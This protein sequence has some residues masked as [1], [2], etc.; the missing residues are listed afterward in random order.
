[1]ERVNDVV[2]AR[3]WP[4]APASPGARIDSL[5]FPVDPDAEPA[6]LHDLAIA[7]TRLRWLA[8][9]SW[10]TRDGGVALP[11]FAERTP[12]L[13]REL[14]AESDSRGPGGSTTH[15]EWAVLD[16]NAEHLADFVRSVRLGRGKGSCLALATGDEADRAWRALSYGIAWRAAL[17]LGGSAADGA[18][19]LH[20]SI[21]GGY[22]DAMAKAGM[23]AI[24]PLDHHPYGGVVVLA[25]EMTVDALEERL[26]GAVRGSS[27]SPAEIVAGAGGP[28]L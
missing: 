28:A 5:W 8:M 18:E 26:P 12:G 15:I 11:G 19:H 22:L 9:G 23:A 16:P 3:W 1:M 13:L 2:E 7:W 6:L 20:A 4:F 14:I 21:V 10:H 27:V 17:A 24:V 25:A